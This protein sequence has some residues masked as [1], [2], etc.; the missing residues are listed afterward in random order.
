MY[1][2]F[3]LLRQTSSHHS[4]CNITAVT[5][6]HH[7]ACPLQFLCFEEDLS[8]TA[9][10]VLMVSAGAGMAH[11]P[12][13][14]HLCW[15]Q[16]SH[17]K[18]LYFGCKVTVKGHAITRKGIT[19]IGW[20]TVKTQELLQCLLPGRQEL[21]LLTLLSIVVALTHSSCCFNGALHKG[22]VYGM[23]L[24]F[25]CAPY[26]VCYFCPSNAVVCVCLLC[27]AAYSNSSL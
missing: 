23:W 15:P 19:Y 18:D 1:Y 12:G 17:F 8:R 9:M 2:Y 7:P 25:M 5:P 3:F 21:K 6:D 27:L 10:P 13:Q 11:I 22:I 20:K 16:V 14:P 24:C 26:W 4:L